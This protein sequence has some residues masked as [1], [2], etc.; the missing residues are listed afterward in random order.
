MWGIRVRNEALRTSLISVAGAEWL[1]AS[2]RSRAWAATSRCHRAFCPGCEDTASRGWRPCT[3]VVMV[4]VRLPAEDGGVAF[5]SED[6]REPEGSLRR[7]V[8]VNSVS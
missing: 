1:G 4:L 7:G 6:C 2:R 5:C 8:T 3:E